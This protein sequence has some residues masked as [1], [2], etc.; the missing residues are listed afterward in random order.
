MRLGTWLFV[1]LAASPALAAETAPKV[2][3]A[4]AVCS[5][6]PDARAQC[7][8]ACASDGDKT[9]LVAWQ[10]GTKF[11]GGPDP[12]IYA[13][14]V[15]AEGKVL[16][17]KPIELPAGQ[18][19]MERPRVAFSGGV[20]LVV[21]QAFDTQGKGWDVCAARVKPDGTLL[22][23]AAIA[24][25]AGPANQ[26][27]P[28]VAPGPNGFLVAWQQWQKDEGY[29]VWA[30]R[31]SPDGGVLEANGVALKDS[32]GQALRGGNVCLTRAGD[33]WQ[34]AWLNAFAI[35]AKGETFPNF[36]ARLGDEGGS[37]KI[38][39]IEQL[40]AGLYYEFDGQI[41]GGTARVLYLNGGAKRGIMMPLA[42][43]CDAATGKALKNPNG[44]PAKTGASGW[45]S[46]Y[47][48]MVRKPGPGSCGFTPPMS[49]GAS[50]DLFLV[51]V[52][53]SEDEKKKTDRQ[54]LH[55]LRIDGKE[56]RRLDS[57]D[58]LPTLDDGATPCFNPAVA[59]GKDGLFLVAYESDGGSGK[60][61]ILARIVK[62]K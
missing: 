15:S 5:H 22:D 21:W 47:A 16:D 32:K 40:P 49:A 27:M 18:G 3:D 46:T 11:V 36:L 56:G 28:D 61:V 31:V 50:G 26:N 29:A 20:F 10:Q 4:V 35:G 41:A 44:D 60:H 54:G 57:L 23:K 59:G 17:A 24:V 9:F 33:A 58:S 45:N 7:L 37:I 30:A 43:V 55:L 34:M 62:A 1:V 2:G 8:P 52:R 14:R 25:A 42:V 12:S 51:A 6:P 53:G 13:A 48:M 38:L 19:S 39:G